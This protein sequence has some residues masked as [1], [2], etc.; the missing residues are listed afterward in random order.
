MENR[1]LTQ[2]NNVITSEWPSKQITLNYD[3]LTCREL[4][5]LA[6]HTSN[7]LSSR[8]IFI[9]LTQNENEAGSIAIF[10]AT[11]TKS[12]QSIETLMEYLQITLYYNNQDGKELEKKILPLLTSRKQ[13]YINKPDDIKNQIL[14]TILVERKLDECANLVMLK[15]LTRKVYFAIGDARESAALIPIFMQAEGASLVQLALNKWMETTKNLPHE[16]SFPKSYSPGLLKNLI[17]IK[18][19]VLNLISTHLDK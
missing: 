9:K 5:E 3:P 10:Y 7:T 16:E 17:Q 13:N 1:L 18:K 11:N 19:W 15:D 2:F 4:F 12:F 8:N 14:K 6:Y